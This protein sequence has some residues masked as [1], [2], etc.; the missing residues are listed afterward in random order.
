MK[1]NKDKGEVEIH[2]KVYL[3]V[4]RRIKDFRDSERYEGWSIT[5]QKSVV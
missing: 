2:G 5:D 1:A 3:T 4:A